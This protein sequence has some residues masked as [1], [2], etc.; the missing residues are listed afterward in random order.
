MDGQD[1]SEV[2]AV[3]RGDPLFLV[4]AG[5]CDEAD[6]GAAQAQVGVLDDQVVDALPVL[7]GER[8]DAQLALGDR[9][10]AGCL[11]L[12]SEVTIVAAPAGPAADGRRREFEAARA[13]SRSVAIRYLFQYC[14]R[15]DRGAAD[16]RSPRATEPD[17][18]RVRP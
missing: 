5:E 9:L 18:G 14:F 17:R 11:N 10:V 4:A 16:K 13:R 6:V 7:A 15:R 12:R 3:Q 1:D 2:P 8:L